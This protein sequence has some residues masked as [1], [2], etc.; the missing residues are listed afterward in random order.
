[1]KKLN[2][3]FALVLFGAISAYAQTDETKEKLE[4]LKGDI[5]KIT[6]ETADGS[7]VIT[8]EDA[9]VLFKK[10]RAKQN[11]MIKNLR[12]GDTNKHKNMIFWKD[13][14][15][16]GNIKI[17]VDVDINDSDS[18]KVIIIKKNIDGKELIEEYKGEEAD[19]FL[20]NHSI[21]N[22]NMEFLSDDGDL[23]IIMEMDSD[24]LDCVSKGDSTEVIKK[25]KVSI[26]DGVKKVTVTSTE[27]GDEKVEVY[28]GEK[29]DKFLEKEHGY[30]MIFH[31][32]DGD[33]KV[34]KKKITIIEE[35]D[36]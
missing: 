16:D 35:D 13:K 33:G 30:K 7:T 14:N 11:I 26:E 12:H 10:M 34:I 22:S 29:A 17:D 25:I 3:I 36:K 2:L 6:I 15:D 27:N 8:G 9:V 4:N 21:G 23:K 1:M 24:E 28:E 32:K 5:T 31:S 20:E 18:G 19:K